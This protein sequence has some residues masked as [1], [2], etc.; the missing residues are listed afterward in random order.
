MVKKRVR[1]RWYIRIWRE[2]PYV[3][4]WSVN[5]FL[6]GTV[7]AGLFYFLKQDVYVAIITS[8]ILMVL[9]EVFERY[10]GIV[11]SLG[12]RVF[13]VITGLVGFGIMVYLMSTAWAPKFPLFLVLFIIFC[14]LEIWGYI[15]YGK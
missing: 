4:F 6:A 7:L 9:W 14:V 5:H 8:F 10:R 11:E 3:D 12:N 13:D 1:K 2:G 15:E